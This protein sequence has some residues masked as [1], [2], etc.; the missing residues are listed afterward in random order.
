MSD[1]KWKRVGKDGPPTGD[2][3]YVFGG[4]ATVPTMKLTLDQPK[5]GS[6][7]ESGHQLLGDDRA[8][9]AGPLEVADPDPEPIQVVGCE[10]PQVTRRDVGPGYSC[11]SEY[12]SGGFSVCVI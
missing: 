7:V 4:V 9:Y 6:L 8:W 3:M 1:L 5:A 12:K 10:E 2:G 11:W